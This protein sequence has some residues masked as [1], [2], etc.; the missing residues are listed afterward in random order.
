MHLLQTPQHLM[1]QS[2]SFFVV[3]ATLL[4]STLSYCSAENVYCVTPT[5]TSCSSC[6]HNST[7]CTTL[8][9]YAQEAELYFTSDTTMVF[10]PGDHILDTYITVTNVTRLTMHGESSSGN[11]A[12]VYCSG[13]VGLS[14]TYMME[15]KMYFLAFTSC[16]RLLRYATKVPGFPLA[17]VCAL[18][19][20]QSAQ[21]AELVKCS[22]H[23][24]NGTALAVTNTSITLAGNNFINNHCESNCIGGAIIALSSNLSFTGNTTFI[25]NSAKFDSSA[26][27][28]IHAS[29]NTVLSFNGTSHFINNS[30]PGDGGA[31]SMYDNTVL[32]FY[33]TS[34]FVNNSADWG[35]GGAISTSHNAVVHFIGI[36]NFSDNSAS[37][38]GAI[39]A[40]NNTALNFNGTSNFINNSAYNGP[41]GAI[42]SLNNTILCFNG[43]NNFINNS[44][45]YDFG[46][47][48]IS[49]SNNTVL[50]FNGASNFINNS[51]HSCA[52][53]CNLCMEQY[54]T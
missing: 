34:N 20:L 22:F 54:C 9:E 40:L 2:I 45:S 50:S 15:F 5:A 30:A 51:A 41:G 27:G 38:G 10:L 33:G 28:A 4:I 18:L 21:Y 19:H 35:C 42:S 3:M 31:I 53:W 24:N 32:S 37:R 36:N 17:S 11:R 49:T 7:N 39:F 8:S 12:T 23:D 6:P 52:W 25:A 26:G 1:A 29:E 13:S 14:F 43:A 47:G 46:C 16:S 44:A 48:A